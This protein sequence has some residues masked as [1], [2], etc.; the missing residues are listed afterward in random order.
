[1]FCIFIQ[2]TAKISK[3]KQGVEVDAEELKVIYGIISLD[4]DVTVEETTMDFM[5]ITGMSTT[6][7]ASIILALIMQPKNVE[8]I[9]TMN[10]AMKQDI[11]IA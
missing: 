9:I 3:N 2:T 1:L 7:G 10:H 6:L 4:E 8:E 5:G 11:W